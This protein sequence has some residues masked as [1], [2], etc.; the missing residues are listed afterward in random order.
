MMSDMTHNPNVLIV[1]TKE[2][3]LKL[4][5]EQGYSLSEISRLSGFSRDTLHRWK[6]SYLKDGLAGLLEKSRTHHHHPNKTD[7]LIEEKIVDLRKKSEF[8][9][10]MQ[11]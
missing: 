9:L 5:L 6:R 10:E 4:Y 2:R 8:N 1:S 7:S 3:W 11:L